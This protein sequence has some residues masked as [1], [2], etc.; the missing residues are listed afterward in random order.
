MPIS[1]RTRG[2]LG[3]YHT[4]LSYVEIRAPSDGFRFRFTPYGEGVRSYLGIVN[5]E[6]KS[7]LFLSFKTRTTFAKLAEMCIDEIVKRHGAPVSAESD[8]DSRLWQSCI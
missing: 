1:Y 3:Y 4:C 6:T 5:R 8:R 7:T 2:L